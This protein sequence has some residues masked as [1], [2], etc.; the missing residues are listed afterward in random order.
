MLDE[1]EWEAMG[2]ALTQSIVDIQNHR[3][4][5]ASLQEALRMPHGLQALQLYEEITGCQETNPDVI[6]RHRISMY[7]PPCDACGK[8]LR[9]PQASFCAACGQRVD[10][11]AKQAE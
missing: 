3:K 7:G 5:G 11:A 2:P 6:R 10:V 4:T 9:T 8:P 1:Q